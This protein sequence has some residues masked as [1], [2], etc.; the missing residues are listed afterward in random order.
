MDN[1]PFI[2]SLWLLT[3]GFETG[4]SFI[5]V[6]LYSIIRVVALVVLMRLHHIGIASINLERSIKHHQRLFNLQ[7]IT[8]VVTDPLNKVTVI[9]LSDPER[10][11]ALIELVC[12]LGEE[13]PVSSILRRGL[14]LYHLC[15]VVEDIESALENARKNGA[16]IISGPNPAK[17]YNGKKIAFI[18][19][20][21]GYIVEFLQE[22]G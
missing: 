3:E 15:Y 19:T 2:F 7:P 12:P 13:S 17:L 6:N 1:A 11:N 18:Y 21:D 10:K 14:S 20:L 8:D 9:L 5:K 4:I 16:K 22:K